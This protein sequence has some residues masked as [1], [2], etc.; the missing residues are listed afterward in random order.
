MRYL[1]ATKK[2][3]NLLFDFSVNSLSGSVPALDYYPAASDVDDRS[4]RGLDRSRDGARRGARHLL[5]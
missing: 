2:L 1:T 3:H 5:R 4:A